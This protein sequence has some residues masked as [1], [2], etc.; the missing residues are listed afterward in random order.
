MTTVERR[1]TYRLQLR[2]EFGFAAA[3]EV[4]P[5]LARLGVSHLYLSP[6]LQTVPGS[7][8]GYDVVDHS[9]LRDELGGE[10]GFAA[11]AGAAQRHGLSI[12]LDIVPNHMA[13]GDR[14]NT[15][16]WDVLANGHASAWS[17][18]FDV[19]WDPPESRLRNRILVPILGDHYGRV[20]ERGEL[21]VRREG[22]DFVVT[23]FDHRLPLAPRTLDDVLGAAAARTGSSLLG[24]LADAHRELPL[25]SATDRASQRRR[26]RDAV[27]L[28]ALLRDARAA[29]PEAEV[30]IDA[31]LAAIT[32]DVDRL[33]GLLERQN[34]R[35]AYWRVASRELDYR[36]FFDINT[37]AALRV[38]DD[39]VFDDTHR[40]V[41]ELHAQGLVDGL[42]IDHV[43]GLRDP[44]GYLDRLRAAAP[45]A[46]IVVEKILAHD[47]ELPP[48]PIAGTS[49]Y[50][51][52]ADAIGLFVDPR[53]AAALS[54]SYEAFTGNTATFAEIAHQAR[55][56]VLA[57]LLD[58]DLSRV[59]NALTDL[60]EQR[61]RHRDHARG[62]IRAALTEVLARFEVYRTYIRPPEP[63][64]DVDR[65]RVDAAVAAAAAARPDLDADVFTLVSSML[66]DEGADPLA[67]RFV[68]RFQQLSAPVM[69]K[70]VEDTATYRYSRL[71]ALNEVG[72]DPER[73]GI[74]PSEFHTH[75]AAR[76]QRGA[77]GLLATSTHDTKRSED[78]R[79]RLCVLSEVP[80]QWRDAVTRWQTANAPHRSDLVDA[81]A[82]HLLY[83]T[84]VGAHPIDADRVAA[85][86][87]KAGREAKVHT[88][89]LVPD[90]AYETA[91]E[92]FVRAVLADARFVSG[93]ADFVA[94]IRDA[95]R[96]NSL[97][98]CLLKLT[99][100]GVPD[101]YQGCELWDLSLTDPDN[102]R[103]VDYAARTRIL[104]D[105]ASLGAAEAWKRADDGTPKQWLIGRALGVRARHPEV[106]APTA[107]YDPLDTVGA[108][109][110][111]VVA[112]ARDQRVVTIVPRLTLDLDGWADTAVVL[113]P[114]RW[115][116]ELG[117]GTYDSNASMTALTAEFPVALL[118]LL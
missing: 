67:R 98:L 56:D 31:E 37:L 18:Y 14:G 116:D 102:R 93:V 106:F 57:Q 55:Y 111:H 60:C 107:A 7:T 80:D 90:A 88:S 78:V 30:A 20:V 28:G 74:S 39:Q 73:A 13:I 97:A 11:L 105:T 9:R 72:A 110:D 16:W 77:H 47:E 10:A 54:E 40:L 32:A 4:V 89:W 29:D 35:L 17:T 38:E 108:H 33:D 99:A 46:W 87:T 75:N 84:L 92:S 62:D 71:I 48:W 59:T 79:T 61:R 66:L 23:Y 43:D 6:V 19:D 85:Y 44:A 24:Y 58:A 82:E 21:A 91:V 104:D 64:S 117:G 3:A 114:G 26:R 50:E 51:F 34:Y 15:W 95:G 65:A 103:P 53:G 52:A 8:H 112:F 113:P 25:A 27:V 41:L 69:A 96:V 5:Y 36:R 70:G 86:M 118:T 1:A 94:A 63:P 81:E 83:Q 22:D 76:A 2:P 101:I 100:P 49:G 109:H 68:A 12:M 115:Q 42:R 45:D